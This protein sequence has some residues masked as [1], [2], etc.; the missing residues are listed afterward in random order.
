MGIAAAIF[1]SKRFNKFLIL[2]KE[3]ML[4]HNPP[5]AYSASTELP[6]ILGASSALRRPDPRQGYHRPQGRWQV[7]GRRLFSDPFCSPSIGGW[8]FRRV[9]SRR[10]VPEKESP[11]RYS[12]R[13]R[14]GRFEAASVGGL[15]ILPQL[16]DAQVFLISALLEEP[17][18]CAFSEVTVMWA[19]ASIN[20]TTRPQSLPAISPL[21]TRRTRFPV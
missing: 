9:T 8:H 15:V 12:H 3:G 19:V 21:G 11:S 18:W 16:I 17:R 2:H 10:I 6:A 14:S 5:P 13:P 1:T 4:V 7:K 20:P